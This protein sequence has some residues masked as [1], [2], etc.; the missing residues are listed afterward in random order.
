[1]NRQEFIELLI[2]QRDWSNSPYCDRILD[3]KNG[4]EC[5]NPSAII[6]HLKSMPFRGNPD[7][8]KEIGIYRNS[9][10]EI[11]KVNLS[12]NTN[13]LYAII[14][15][16][17]GDGT[18]SWEYDQ[19]PKG[20]IHKLHSADKL[21]MSLEEARE[22]GAMY[23][24]CGICGR[25]LNNSISVKLGIGPVCGNRE[26]GEEFKIL[27]KEVKVLLEKETGKDVNPF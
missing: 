22:F 2:D 6:D 17:N 7:P 10:G 11:Y 5:T 19:T 8:V 23:N 21:V 3:I 25:I 15:Y 9:A 13:R 26:Y 4:A 16:K 1:M 14:L 24:Y 12:K 20:A 18:Y 27:E